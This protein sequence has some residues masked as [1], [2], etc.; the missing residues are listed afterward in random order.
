MRVAG[1]AMHCLTSAAVRYRMMFMETAYFPF[2]RV[3]FRSNPFRALTDEEWAGVAILSP[4]VCAAADGAG[5]MQIL[6]P[7][8]RGKTTLLLGLA[9]RFREQGKRAVYEY[10]PQ[11]R[12]R[13]TTPL[14]GPDIFLLDEA[15]RL[16][17]RQA[18][19]LLRRAAQTRPGSLRLVLGTHADMSPRFARRNL[20]LA[21]V[22]P[23]EVSPAFLA[24]LLRRRLAFFALDSAPAAF[25]GDAVDYLRAAF[26]GNLRA[27]TFFLYEVFQDMA[28]SGVCPAVITAGQ[29]RQFAGPFKPGPGP[30]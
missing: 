17:P 8:G 3:G 25:S 21:T 27:M 4:A 16:V 6:G 20:P 11:G 14:D 15:Q 1:I 30:E 19:R 13:F 10:V 2:Y 18:R 23:A 24:R 26:G 9:A 7:R 29:L 28:G 22:R 5:H 12:S